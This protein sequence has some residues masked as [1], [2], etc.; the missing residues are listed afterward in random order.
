HRGRAIGPQP[1]GMGRL[2]LLFAHVEMF[3]AG[4][5]PPIDAAGRLAGKEAAILPEIFSRTGAPAALQP[6]GEGGRRG[7]RL[8]DQGRHGLRERASVAARALRCPGLVFVRALPCRRH[9]TYPMRA[10]S[11]PIT[12]CMLSP[13]ARAAKVSAMRCLRIGSAMATTSSIEGERRPSMS[14]RARA[15]SISAWLARGLAPPA[16]N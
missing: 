7:A 3:V 14:A 4:G 13:S 1:H 16:L 10:L 2:P 12:P 11:L 9:A 15:T 5:A 8:A 6:L